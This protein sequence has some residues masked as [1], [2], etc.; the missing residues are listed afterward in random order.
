MI[1][2]ANSGGH[3]LIKN[4]LIL[5]NT[6]SILLLGAPGP[7]FPDYC[8]II[9]NLIESNAWY[10]LIVQSDYNTI[11]QNTFVNNN[12]DGTSQAA[13]SGYHNMWYN[14]SL[15]EGNYWSNW[16]GFATY[17]IDGSAKS[18]DLYPS[19]RPFHVTN[20][21]TPKV[22]IGRIILRVSLGLGYAGFVIISFLIV[23]KLKKREDR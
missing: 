15:Q 18:N 9:H 13:D 17:Q 14:A 8:L 4:N 22:F 12:P 16:W 10:G 21:P 23:I 7:Y 6:L 1:W 19:E 20:T 3:F 11:F 2:L 5:N